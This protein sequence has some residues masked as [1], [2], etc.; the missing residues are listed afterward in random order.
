[1]NRER[2]QNI[3]INTKYSMWNF[4]CC[5]SDCLSVDSI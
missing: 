2:E 1:M 3:A 4:L 5:V